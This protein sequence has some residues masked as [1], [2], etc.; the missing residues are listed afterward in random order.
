MSTPHLAVREYA[1]GPA[2]QMMTAAFVALVV[3]LAA[4]AVALSRRMRTWPGR[5]G[6]ALL[7]IAASGV[8]LAAAHPTDP[9]TLPVSAWAGC[10]PSPQPSTKPAV[11]PPAASSAIEAGAV[12]GQ[13]SCPV[14][15]SE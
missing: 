10:S 1:L 13:Q 14:T 9:I 2:G 7:I 4:A 8:A 11:T 15:L 6:L 12:A 3:S 5:A